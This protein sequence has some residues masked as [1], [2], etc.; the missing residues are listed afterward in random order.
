MNSGLA[1]ELFNLWKN[2]PVWAG[3][4]IMGSTIRELVSQGLATRD[5]NGDYILTD[6]GKATIH[7]S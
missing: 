5:K 3:D 6:K 2:Q 7:P 4:T 1:E